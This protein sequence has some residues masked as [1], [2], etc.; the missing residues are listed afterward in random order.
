MATEKDFRVKN[1]LIVAGNATITGSISAN[2]MSVNGTTLAN[3]AT[4]GAYSDL[5]GTPTIPSATS[6]L[7]NDSGFITTSAL[8]SYATQTYVNTSVANLVDSAPETL[9]TLN[10]LS[11]ALGDDPNFATTI[12]NQ[13]GLK[14]NTADLATVATTGA[15]SDLS[16]T[17][18]IPTVVSDLTNDAGYVI[19]STQTITF[20]TTEASVV[21][22]WALSSYRSATYN[23][24]IET[25]FGFYASN[26]KILQ[27]DTND[28]PAVRMIEYAVI[29]MCFAN[30][31]TFNVD[32]S[33]SNVRLLFTPSLASDVAVSFTKTTLD[34]PSGYIPVAIAGDLNNGS[35]T[36]DMNDGSAI[37]DLV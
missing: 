1:G 34:N 23:I 16:G 6:D 35:S 29:D 17:P 7:T 26:I 5:S 30:P 4:S 32:I 11:A 20:N 13:I 3:V 33:S 36:I 22:S 21:D 28:P 14:A 31:G 27:D 9:N 10:E 18:T 19:G 37:V 24:A 12:S 15:Y 8:T 25:G 2:S